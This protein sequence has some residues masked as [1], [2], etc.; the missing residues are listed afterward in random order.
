M[1][2][3]SQSTQD[4]VEWLQNNRPANNPG[5][6]K[7]EDWEVELVA[8]QEANPP[9]NTSSD[10]IMSAATLPMENGDMSSDT[11]FL[12]HAGGCLQVYA[13][14]SLGL[15][16]TGCTINIS[17]FEWMEVVKAEFYGKQWKSKAENCLGLG[18]RYLQIKKKDH[19]QAQIPQRRGVLDLPSPAAVVSSISVL[20]SFFSF[21]TL[22]SP[23][24][25][26]LS[27]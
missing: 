3:S 15:L 16:G 23:R 20:C 13:A 7:S 19:V 9:S 17:G 26:C 10:S 8:Y 21:P 18:L 14:L 1:S 5:A 6:K 24:G 4:F 25:L 11:V 22:R 2:D 12:N 27:L